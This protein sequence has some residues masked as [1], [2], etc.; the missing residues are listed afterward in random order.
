MCL[1]TKFV[2]TFTIGMSWGGGSCK[3]APNPSPS[4][5]STLQA[6]GGQRGRR[7]REH[8]SRNGPDEGGIRSPSRRF[9]EQASIHGSRQRRRQERTQPS[10]QRRP[11][12]S[13]PRSHRQGKGGSCSGSSS[14]RRRRRRPPPHAIMHL[15]KMIM[16]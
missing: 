10:P 5:S 15:F 9:G 6:T 3:P 7:A 13:R 16:R 14:R 4:L 12:Q 2:V 8:R 1:G 11:V